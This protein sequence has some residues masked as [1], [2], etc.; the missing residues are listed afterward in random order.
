[1]SSSAEVS[2]RSAME[3]PT[4][5]QT[6]CEVWILSVCICKCFKVSGGWSAGAVSARVS[7]L[8]CDGPNDVEL[9]GLDF[10][11]VTHEVR[12]TSVNLNLLLLHINRS[13]RSL[14]RRRG[15]SCFLQTDDGELSPAEGSDGASLVKFIGTF[16]RVYFLPN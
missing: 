13:S 15:R 9:C 12:R 16:S 4:E 2:S 8:S 11:H 1:M 5:P 3:T 7:T 6:S 10:T 14:W